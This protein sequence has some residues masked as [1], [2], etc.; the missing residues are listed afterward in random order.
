[1][2][3]MEIVAAP[4]ATSTFYMHYNGYLLRSTSAGSSGSWANLTAWTA[5]SDT[6]NT[7]PGQGA[8]GPLIAVDPQNANIIFAGS[9]NTG[10]SGGLYKSTDGGTT[11]APVATVAQSSTAVL[12]AFDPSSSVSGNAK[13]GI[14]ACSY[15]TGC[16]HSTNGG[17]AWSSIVSGGPTQCIRIMVDA[18]GNLWCA[19]LTIWKYNGS[20]WSNVYS[21]NDQGG[22][23]SIAVDPTTSGASEHVFAVTHTGNLNVSL[24]A[25]STWSGP[26]G[27]GLPSPLVASTDVPW[28]AATAQ[29]FMTVSEIA[30]D[31]AATSN[32]YGVAGTGV[33]H[34]VPPTS[35]VTSTALTW[36]S[37]TAGQ[38]TLV[39]NVVLAPPSGVPNV[40]VW[41]R[42]TFQI[43]NKSTYSNSQ[44]G[45]PAV[46]PIGAWAA[47]WATGTPTTLVMLDSTAFSSG[48]D[49]SGISTNG[50]QT[51]AQF[52]SLP[53]LI[54]DGAFHGGIAAGG[55]TDFM[56]IQ[57]GTSGLPSYTGNSGASWA[58]ITGSSLPTDGWTTNGVSNRRVVA[59]RVTA[60]TYYIANTG[61][62]SPGIYTCTAGA[63]SRTTTSLADSGEPLLTSV[64][65][66]AGHIFANFYAHSV[67][68]S[69]N[70]GV[71]WSAA[72]SNGSNNFSTISAIGFGST[73]AG[74]SYPSIY[75]VGLDAGGTYGV[76]RCINF[77]SATGVGTW[78]NLGYPL[79]TFNTIQWID[80][81]KTTPQIV[82]LAT[83]GN[84]AIQG[85]F[86]FLLKRDLDPAVNDNAPMFLNEAA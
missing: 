47:D 57:G 58:N 21:T 13:Q 43:T 34:L 12:A 5:D 1:M 62:T 2:G 73:F 18:A 65:G 7:G 31:P 84:G 86:N 79:N 72:L 3:V 40:F 8:V 49:H 4:S 37:Q 53:S 35:S 76:W 81:D 9:N 48:S 10:A 30:F 6:S 63:C 41:D 39:G 71:T 78:T 11:L 56:Y 29:G 85:Y 70:G 60:N 54:G 22:Y 16:Y 46:S 14:Y 27:T 55:A 51:W 69:I 24:N 68:F 61:A 36:N 28:L 45:F 82:Y 52:A 42:S 83:N 66:K 59:D 19:D 67:R 32:L 33:F 38:E 17:S 80:G 23:F 26:A 15:G 64:P 25:G 50:G 74:Q 77:N 75:I 44:T 20:A